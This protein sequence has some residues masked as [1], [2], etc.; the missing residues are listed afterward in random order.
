VSGGLDEAAAPTDGA[1]DAATQQAG[2]RRP[3]RLIA[4][5]VGVVGI[6]LIVLLATRPLGE[7]ST[8]SPL[9]GELAPAIQATDTSGAPFDVDAYRG[10]WLLLNFFATWC[11]PCVVEHPELVR[12]AERHQLVGDAAVA[13]V[14]FNEQPSVVAEFFDANG[15]DWPVVAEGN[16]RF[17]LEYGV[18][19][20]PESYLIAPDGTVV[21][22]F[23]GGITADGVD[24]V[25][26]QL[27]GGAG[28]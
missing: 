19:R 28:S 17:A 10:R 22:K 15:G 12:F 7:R 21:H 27:S 11:G 16:G 24:A 9:L 14:A 1:P 20:L 8:A 26:D 4:V 5:A 23:E 2:R 3:T 18:V 6:G 25:I 13:S